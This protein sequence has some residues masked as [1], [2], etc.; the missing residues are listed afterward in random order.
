[1]IDHDLRIKVIALGFLGSVVGL[2]LLFVLVEAPP[3][4]AIG[5]LV[6]A[7]SIL[8]PALADSTLEDRRRKRDSRYPSEP[9]REPRS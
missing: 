1:M 2:I 3:A 5:A 9:P 4:E 7:M 6:T 8:G